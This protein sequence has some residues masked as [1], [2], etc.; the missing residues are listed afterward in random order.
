MITLNHWPSIPHKVAWSL[1]DFKII[2]PAGIAGQI[3]L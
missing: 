1:Y 2:R 3:F